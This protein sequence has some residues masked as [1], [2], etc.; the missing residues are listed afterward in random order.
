MKDLMD[1]LLISPPRAVAQ[2]G[3]FPPIGLGYLCA[4]LKEA[5]ID[6]MVLDASALSWKRLV[7][8]IR[9]L[10]PRI[11][12]ITCFTLERSQSFRVATLVREILR[13]AKIIFGGHHATA[14]P[15]HILLQGHADAVVIG[16]GEHTIVDLARALLDG[17]SLE[18]VKGI[19]YR[20]GSD[21]RLTAPRELIKDLDSI[22]YPT[23][24]DFNLDDYLGFP[25][26]AGRTT[27]LISSRGCPYRCTFCSGGRFWKHKWRARSAENVLGEIQ[28]LHDVHGVRNISIFDDNFAVR[29]DRVIEICK[30]ILD[31]G[32]QIQW[33]VSSHV[34][35]MRKEMLDWMKKAGCFR[36]DFGVE[37]GS[38]KI[39]ENVQKGQTPEQIREAFRLVHEA[40]IK[41]KAYLMVGNPGED[42]QT[43]D[44]TIQ[45]MGEIK[46]YYSNTGGILWILPGTAI[47]EIA[48][49]QGLID[50][51]FW[52]ENEGVV[53]YTGEHTL[54]ELLALKIRLMRG[55]A[56]NQ[57]TAKAM[58]EF[59]A[60]KAYYRWPILQKLRGLRFLFK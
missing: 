46:P 10:S 51:D 2:S 25:E 58:A 11:V 17:A 34:A 43:I 59:W 26:V 54:E 56:Y 7:E 15:Q 45:L 36:I 44:D 42:E 60:R 27:C 48:K 41:P 3:D 22:P 39:L 21:T 23:C 33:T 18:K 1:I 20:D 32:L 40:D 14:F 8:R 28:W 31:R 50:D 16:E 55:M 12:G 37:S 13:G 35:H 57:G 4:V 24:S 52:L 9:T 19:A 38:I 6:A 49:Q 5:Q 30:G 53:Y 47:Y 29:N